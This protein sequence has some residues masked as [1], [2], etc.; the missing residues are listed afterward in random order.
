[1]KPPLKKE[2]TTMARVD[3]VEPQEPGKG[4]L[5]TPPDTSDVNL[6]SIACS[7]Y[8]IARTLDGGL[9][10]DVKTDR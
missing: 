8:K 4:S 10:V 1:M 3:L 7:L 5:G 6:Y 2:R 9:N